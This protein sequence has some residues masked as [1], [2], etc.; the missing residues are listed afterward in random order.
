MTLLDD[1]AS[2]RFLVVTGK[3]GVGKTVV[4]AVLGRLLSGAGRSVLLLE[5]D[6]RENLHEL[7]GVAPSGGEVVTVRAHLLL[8]NLQP[9]QVLEQVVRDHLRLEWLSRRVVTSPVFKH[10]VDAAPG[11]KELAILG[12]AY[13]VLHGLAANLSVDMVVLDAPATGHGLSMLTAPSVVSDVIREGPFGSMAGDL[14]AFVADPARTAIVVVTHAEEMPIQESLELRA[15]MQRRV[16]RSPDLLVVN[17]LY[18]PVKSP[19]GRLSSDPLARLW[20]RRR[21]INDREL[22]RLEQAW[23]G[24]RVLLPFVPIDRGPELPARLAPEMRQA[25][26]GL[27]GAA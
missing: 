2:R 7:A 9:R 12:H 14:K 15:E 11:L 17:A 16:K 6:P 3:G 23:S 27:E 25:L 20:I 5:V 18:P 21:Q 8:Q 24:P 26:L 1:L 22:S 13:R 4:S 19:G 10:F